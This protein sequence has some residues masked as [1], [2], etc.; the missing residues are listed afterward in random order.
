MKKFRFLLLSIFIISILTTSC[1][2][3]NPLVGTWEF[4]SISDQKSSEDY[5]YINFRSFITFS[6]DNTFL[7]VDRGDF[8]PINVTEFIDDNKKSK[9]G[10][11]YYGSWTL[12]D[13]ILVFDIKNYKMSKKFTAK[14]FSNDG[15]NLNLHFSKQKPL[16]IY[17]AN[18]EFKYK[19]IDY[20]DVSKSKNNFTSLELNKWRINSKKKESKK[21]IKDKVENALEFAINFL[22]FHQQGNDK[23]AK[24]YYLQPL[25]F[26]FYSNGIILKHEN[27]S[28]NW[29]NLFYDDEDAEIAYQLLESGFN[30]VAKI[31]DNLSK[32]PLKINIFILQETLKNIK[33]FK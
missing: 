6:S 18:S 31:P 19:K 23:S 12:K 14:I 22:E 1:S 11:I 24:T 33:E 16:L 13:S 32:K 17:D 2:K 29:N 27:E 3:K 15:K 20:D 8:D 30:N 21:E 7:F 4:V 5:D 10:R 26:Q 28:D 25:P 9:D